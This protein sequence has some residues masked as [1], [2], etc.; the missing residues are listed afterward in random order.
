MKYL[1]IKIMF[2]KIKV[3]TIVVAL[4]IANVFSGAFAGVYVFA[5]FN[6]GNGTISDINVVKQCN[7]I[8]MMPSK[9]VDMCVTI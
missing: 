4:L 6:F 1:P 7:Q 2:K 9:F 8:A 3:I 5:S